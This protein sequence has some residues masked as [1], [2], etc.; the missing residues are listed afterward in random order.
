MLVEFPGPWFSFT[1]PLAATWRQVEEIHAA[2]LEVI[3]A[4]PERCPEIQRQPDVVLPFVDGGA[5][6][7]FNADSFIGAHGPAAERCGWQL[8][9]LGVGDLIASDAHRLSRPSRMHEAVD[10][11]AARYGLERALSLADGSALARVAGRVPER[12]R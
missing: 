7:C 12:S 11:L 8:L 2:G 1:D 6:V 10:V 9:E 5:L 4:H 3:L